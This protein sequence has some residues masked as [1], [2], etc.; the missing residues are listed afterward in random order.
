MKK[1]F[2]FILSAVVAAAQTYV[3][4]TTVLRDNIDP[5]TIRPGQ[6]VV[7]QT[8]GISVLYYPVNS[9]ASITNSVSFNSSKR[10]G[11]HW[12]AKWDGNARAFNVNANNLTDDRANIQAAIDYGRLTKTGVFIDGTVTSVLSGPISI[13]SD[14]YVYGRGGRWYFDGR[15]SGSKGDTNNGGLFRTVNAEFP[16]WGAPLSIQHTNI[17]LESLGFLRNWPLGGTNTGVMLMIDHATDV[18][19]RDI[20]IMATNHY[21]WATFFRANNLYGENIYIRTPGAWGQDGW[22]YY[23]GTNMLLSGFDILAGDDAVAIGNERDQYIE[24]VDVGHGFAH[25][26]ESRGIAIFQATYS[27]TPP[28][29]PTNKLRYVNIHDV[30]SHSGQKT[31]WP[32]VIEEYG[33]PNNTHTVEPPRVV[34]D[35]ILDNVITT[36][37]THQN[38]GS[39]AIR[40]E[41]TERVTIQNTSI[42]N[43]N[44]A[45]IWLNKAKDV[46]L[47]NVSMFKTVRTG[48]TGG[49]AG[50]YAFDT[51]LNGLYINGGYYEAADGLHTILIRNATN[52]FIENARIRN[53]D[54]TKYGIWT[55]T[56]RGLRI[57]GNWFDGVGGAINLGTANTNVQIFGNLFASTVATNVSWNKA[58]VNTY[59]EDAGTM[60]PARVFT[61]EFHVGTTTPQ[62]NAAFSVTSTTKGIQLN[63]MSQAQV[64]A[65]AGNLGLVAVDNDLGM[66]TAHDGSIWRV[67]PLWPRNRISVG[68]SGSTT[69]STIDGTNTPVIATSSNSWPL[70]ARMQGDS[71]GFG[72]R[73]MIQRALSGGAPVPSGYHLGGIVLGGAAETNVYT[74]GDVGLIG[75][76][77]EA[78]ATNA[79]GAELVISATVNGQTNRTDVAKF[80][81]E[82]GAHTN[83]MP[84][85]LPDSQGRWYRLV[86]T[87]TGGE[88][89]FIP[90]YTP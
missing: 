47:N 5:V 7:V 29:P 48:S 83:Y 17:W 54:A 6:F 88:A 14:T 60:Y 75:V 50:L 38:G 43:G 52:V 10:S 23:S 30:I 25:S 15:F 58:N 89:K 37:G 20:R 41:G 63:R 4:S 3:T 68:S 16:I 24:N 90:V 66:I 39:G 34:T 45:G 22:H 76:T 53:P 35:I 70:L 11:W 44:F 8:N 21:D 86:I 2:I 61:P 42:T 85:K 55:D 77:T 87:N 18:Y 33:G 72:A 79:N 49:S 78:F 81:A 71:V 36:R 9:A 27:T 65:I 31:N 40:I 73:L 57:S 74:D 84:L 69:F 19:L 51:S 80:N 62:A 67:V 12:K 1:L 82:W 32:I 46:T 56:I 28:A 13:G 26:Q 64:D 59:V